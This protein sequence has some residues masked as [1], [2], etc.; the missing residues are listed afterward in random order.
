MSPRPQKASAPDFDEAA[1]ERLIEGVGS[2]TS[3]AWRDL[4]ALLWP[5][6]MRILRASRAMVAFAKS[7]D[8]VRNAAVLVLDKLGKDGCRVASLYRPWRDAH[9]EKSLRHWLTIVT[10]NVARD[11]VKERTGRAEGGPDKRLLASLAT[12]LPDDDDLDALLP[13]S[14]LSATSSHAAHE[15]LRWADE[16]L[17]PEQRA[18]LGAWL[19]GTSFEEMA[20][21]IRVADGPAA[22]RVVRAA[23]AV[24]RRHADAA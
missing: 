20:I 2:L 10:T 4:V 1:C 21:Q 15:L 8:H 6:L 5:E 19:E 22:K 16:R 13:S 18:A 12:F 14:M 9:P 24:L 7:E 23:I 17:T 3:P 11:Y